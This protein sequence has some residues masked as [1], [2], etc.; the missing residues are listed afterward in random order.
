VSEAHQIMVKAEKLKLDHI[1]QCTF[2]TKPGEKLDFIK[3]IFET[4]ETT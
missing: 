4:T 1:H 2:T 3:E